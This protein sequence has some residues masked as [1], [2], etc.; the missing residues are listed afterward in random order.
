MEIITS[1]QNKVVKNA[2]KIREESQKFFFLEGIKIINEALKAGLV[3]EYFL[4]DERE[5]ESFRLNFPFI[6]EKDFYVLSH[7]VFEKVCDTKTPQGIVAIVKF[8]VK[9]PQNLQN[10]FLVLENIQD[11]ANVGA[12]IRSASGT[13]FKDIFLIDCV[14]IFNQKVVRS[15]MGRMFWENLYAF[16]TF[17]EFST[18]FKDKNSTLWVADLQGENLFETKIPQTVFGVVIGNEGK[19]VSEKMKKLAQK[20]IAIPM[21]NGLESLNAGISAAIITYFVDNFKI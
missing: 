14:S 9:K 11:P 10:N 7:N 3:P 1:R 18:F 4:V 13:S 12:I 19:G 20:T 21:K 6:F 8:D 5:V 2:I 16:K 17:E 15:A